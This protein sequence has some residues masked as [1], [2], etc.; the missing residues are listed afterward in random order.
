MPIALQRKYCCE[1][2]RVF[3]SLRLTA[4]TG[5][6]KTEAQIPGEELRKTKPLSGSGYHNVALRY[7]DLQI[8]NI[9]GKVKSE[10]TEG[11]GGKLP[12]DIT[13]TEICKAVCA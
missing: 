13:G 8:K 9:K 1:A 6:W 7:Y 11:L 3:F 12:L 5:N 10:H 2:Q 4:Y